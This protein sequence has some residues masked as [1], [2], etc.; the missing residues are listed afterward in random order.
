VLAIAGRYAAKLDYHIAWLT[1]ARGIFH[2][3]RVF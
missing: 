1:G 2:G 3:G